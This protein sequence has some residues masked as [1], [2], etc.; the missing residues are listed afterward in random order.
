MQRSKITIVVTQHRNL[1]ELYHQFAGTTAAHC[2]TTQKR[3]CIPKKCALLPG[4]YRTS[5]WTYAMLENPLRDSRGTK[6]WKTL[7]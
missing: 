3:T 1:A 4:F 7:S 2:A 6:Q 5:P